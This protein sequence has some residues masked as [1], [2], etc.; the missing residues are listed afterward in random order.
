MNN[1][2]DNGG[3][4]Y[5]VVALQASVAG[6][7]MSIRDYFAGQAMLAIMPHELS[8]SYSQAA[9]DS[10][11]MADAMIKEREVVK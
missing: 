6:N 9:E 10:Y 1:I 11:K 5:P 8:F 4:A 2:K 7:G 3:P